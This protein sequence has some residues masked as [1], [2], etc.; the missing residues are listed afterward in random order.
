MPLIISDLSIYTPYHLQ[1]LIEFVFFAAQYRVTHNTICL[2]VVLKFMQNKLKKNP[3][4]NLSVC[5]P[6]STIE[7]QNPV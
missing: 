6:C 1:S 5:V 3:F 4:K 7:E 2:I